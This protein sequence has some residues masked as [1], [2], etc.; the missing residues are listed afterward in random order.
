MPGDCPSPGPK[1][2]LDGEVLWTQT[3]NL[4]GVNGHVIDDAC[5]RQHPVVKDSGEACAT[6]AEKW[7]IPPSNRGCEWEGD[8]RPMTGMP[9]IID[10]LLAWLCVRS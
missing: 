3:G 9:D 1:N 7:A 10:H 2:L 6:R 8:A 5:C 4:N